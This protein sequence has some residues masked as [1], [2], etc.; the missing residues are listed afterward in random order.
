MA[1]KL[2]KG[3]QFGFA[4]V[5]AAKIPATGFSKADPALASVAAGTVSV[6]EV[7]LIGAPGWPMLNNRVAEAGAESAGAV[8]LLGV[9]TT[10][11]TLYPG[12]SGAGSVQIAGDFIDFTQQGDASTSGGDQQYWSGTLL[13]DPTGRQIQIPTTKNAKTLTLP[14]YFDPALPWYKAA[15]AV[16]AKGEPV[17]LRG[18]LPGGDCIYWYGYMSFDGDPSITSNT[19]MGNTMTFTAL[20]DSTLVEAI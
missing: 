7:V 4:P 20:S 10:D 3:T 19:P 2:P 14:L 17:I 8:E 11:A 9:D 13:E 12:I 6:G 18:K 15:K 16:D 1:L 5:I